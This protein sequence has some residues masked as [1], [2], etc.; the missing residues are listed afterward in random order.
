MKYKKRDLLLIL[1]CVLLCLALSG[2]GNKKIEFNRKSSVQ[3]VLD[4]IHYKPKEK[5]TIKRSKGIII[6]KDN[7]YDTNSNT[8]KFGPGDINFDLK[9]KFK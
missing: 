3:Q 7:S 6:Y 4:D 2:C 5:R 1:F 9:V 8:I